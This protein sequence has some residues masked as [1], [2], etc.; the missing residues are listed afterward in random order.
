MGRRAADLTTPVPVL[1]VPASV[2]VRS[3]KTTGG[4]RSGGVLLQTWG[5]CSIGIQTSPGISRP[6]VQLPDSISNNVTQTSNTNTTEETRAISVHLK[7]DREKR[8]ILR[9]K[10]EETKI[11]KEVTFKALG[12]V[13]SKNLAGCQKRS[14]GTYCYAKAIKTNPL[15]AGTASSS[16]PRLKSSTRYING[17]VVDSEAIGGIIE[18]KD[19]PEPSKAATSHGTVSHHPCADQSKNTCNHCGG[20]QSVIS[21]GAIPG[22]TSPISK[23]LFVEKASKPALTSLFTATHLQLP[24]TL[25]QSQLNSETKRVKNTPIASNPHL[26]YLNEEIIYRQTP[27][28]ACPVHSRVGPET[29]YHTHASSDVTSFQPEAILQTKTVTVANA[30][31]ESRQENSTINCFAK[32]YQNNKISLLSSFCSKPQMATATK[33]FQ[34]SPKRLKTSSH[35]SL[36]GHITQ[37]VCVSVHAVPEC[38]PLSLYTVAMGTQRTSSPV[39]QGTFNLER[40]CPH[41]NAR[42]APEALHST[43]QAQLLESDPSSHLTMASSPSDSDKCQEKPPSRAADVSPAKI[44]FVDNAA[45]FPASANPPQKPAPHPL[46]SAAV[47][48]ITLNYRINPDQITC[49][50][51]TDKAL[52]PQIHSVKP[53]SSDS[54]TAL[55]ISAS[56]PRTISGASKSPDAKVESHAALLNSIAGHCT[57][58]K[59]TTVKTEVKQVTSLPSLG[60]ERQDNLAASGTCLLPLTDPTEVR[61]NSDA[62][63]KNK[64]HRTQAPD[65]SSQNSHKPC[66]W[67]VV[68]NQQSNSIATLLVKSPNMLETAEGGSETKSHH[69][70]P[71]ISPTVELQCN[72]N[73]CSD[74]AVNELVVH[75]SEEHKN[76]QVINLQNCFP[77]VMSSTFLSQGC[78]DREK[79]SLKISKGFTQADYEGHSATSPLGHPARHPCSNAQ[80]FAFGAAASRANS[81]FESNAAGQ[82][83]LGYSSP[84]VATQTNCEPNISQTNTEVKHITQSTDCQNSNF[85]ITLRRQ[86]HTSPERFVSLP[87]SLTSEGGLSPQTGPEREFDLQPSAM[88]SKSSFTLQSRELEEISRPDLKFSPAAPQSGPEATRLSHSHPSD[89]ALL[90]PPSPQCCRSAGLEQRLKTVEAS[91]AANKDRITIL[92]NIIQDLETCNAPNSLRRYHKSELDLRNCS[93]CQKTA[94]IVYSV[95]YDF[96]Q[97]ERHFLEVL[98]RS[99]GDSNS[100]PA[101]LAEPLNLSLLRNAISKNLTK[102]KLKSKKLCKT[103]LKWIP[104]KKSSVVDLCAPSM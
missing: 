6:L 39:A 34:T 103:L 62:N 101:H 41:S 14:G 92:L 55:H 72:K 52:A 15:T 11:K 64:A 66:F 18:V 87:A 94:C 45:Q 21:R 79:Q 44:S 20:M 58:Y 104:R 50:G 76:S 31:I 63:D 99:P 8:A 35:H 16:R 7:N 28:P 70:D 65:I 13:D 24:C 83:H 97:Q 51:S 80:Q 90:L 82:K 102:T 1:G 67:G 98:N 95:E 68:T 17:S 61:R 43:H 56:S 46:L 74:H 23:A 47:P 2:G 32:P 4:D 3:W 88:L 37:N 73:K 48:K 5:Q 75:K 84:P 96:R 40:T 22:E 9:Q 19:D 100:F 71:T 86:P 25:K 42:P 30:R 12:G 77:P 26:Y 85:D 49:R 89:A 10:T 36:Q 38:P 60:R 59:N 93:T 29:V 81:T 57:V 91:L 27:H 54:G 69:T 33:T 53:N 78:L